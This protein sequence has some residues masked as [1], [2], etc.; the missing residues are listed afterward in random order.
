MTMK[1]MLTILENRYMDNGVIL[2]NKLSPFGQTAFTS[3][4]S[5]QT[6]RGKAGKVYGPVPN[7]KSKCGS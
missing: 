5:L 3:P 7:R 6:I 4:V 1:V 2:E